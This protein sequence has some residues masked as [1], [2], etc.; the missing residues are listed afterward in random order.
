MVFWNLQ[1]PNE[2]FVHQAFTE[3]WFCFAFL[4][5]SRNEWPHISDEIFNDTPI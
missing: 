5:N 1:V 3:I 4:I 2:I